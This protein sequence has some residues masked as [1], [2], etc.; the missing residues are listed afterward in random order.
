VPTDLIV[1]GADGDTVDGL[2]AV[3]PIL[4]LRD[5]VLFPQSVLPLA[6]GR[7]SSARLVE[8]A[9]R[10]GR[11]IGVF[12]QRAPGTRIRRR[13]TSREALRELDRLSTMPLAAA[14]YTVARTYL[15]WLLAR[16]PLAGSHGS[17]RPSSGRRASSSRPAAADCRPD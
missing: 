12:A 3:M 2:P 13:P 17:A 1:P 4:P 16:R 14:E 5:P 7:A 8:E 10:S 15:D 6:A 11:L 9:A